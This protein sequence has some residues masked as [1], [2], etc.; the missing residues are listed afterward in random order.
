M[1]GPPAG[2]L[3]RCQTAHQL[4]PVP[5]DRGLVVGVGAAD[6]RGPPGQQ[7]P[8]QAAEVPLRAAVGAR[9]VDDVQPH[10]AGQLHEADG[11]E[12]A[13][14]PELAPVG[15]VGV[16]E[17]VRLDGVAA[18]VEQLGQ[19]VPPVRPR[20]A[21]VVQR[22]A[23]QPEWPAAQL[24]PVPDHREPTG[25]SSASAISWTDP[26]PDGM[27]RIGRPRSAERGRRGAAGQPRHGRTDKVRRPPPRGM[28]GGP[29]PGRPRTRAPS[30][31]PRPPPP[32]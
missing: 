1:M 6:G 14:E 31:R 29:S 27:Y 32:L 30:G 17:A 23:Q 3:E 7:P 18:Q 13:V 15:F 21:G 12:H 24:E 20:D 19:A 25:P 26:A 5:L 9:P 22:P 4:G 2:R 10:G 16:P 28:F 11:V 8:G